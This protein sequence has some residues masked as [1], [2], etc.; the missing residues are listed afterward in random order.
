MRAQG[1]VPNSRTTGTPQD[2]RAHTPYPSERAS[3]PFSSLHLLPPPP[4]LS[5][6]FLYPLPA[7]SLSLVLQSQQLEMP[8]WSHPSSTGNLGEA[9]SL[10]HPTPT[11]F[12]LRP[13]H[14]PF[15]IYHKALGTPSFSGFWAVPALGPPAAHALYFAP[16]STSGWQGLTQDACL[17]FV[18]PS[19]RKSALVNRTWMSL[20]S[21][22]LPLGPSPNRPSSLHVR[23]LHEVSC[24]PG[25]W[26]PSSRMPSVAAGP[27]ALPSTHKLL[28]KNLFSEHINARELL[29]FILRN[30]LLPGR[31][32][33]VSLPRCGSVCRTK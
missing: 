27:R 15:P 7:F 6:G 16:A 13:P 4:P 17:S 9:S 33:Q 1:P 5:G 23:F 20:P 28:Q 29:G 22:A 25:S 8:I 3:D 11:S 21:T 14:S 2:A 12:A 19:P 18:S 31:L 32:H 26:A 30:P 10:A 24:R